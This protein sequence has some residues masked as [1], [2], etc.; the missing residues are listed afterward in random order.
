MVGL[1]EK[2]KVTEEECKQSLEN[3]RVG[4]TNYRDLVEMELK[5]MKNINDEEIKRKNR[6][7]N[8]IKEI[9]AI[10]RTPRLYRKYF[11][12]IS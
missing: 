10:L 2:V 1:H 6:M 9:K 3:I 11:E 7:F 4:T 8:Q 5:I 12:Y